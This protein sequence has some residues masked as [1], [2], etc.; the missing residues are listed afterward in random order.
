V[1]AARAANRLSTSAAAG[2]DRRRGRTERTH[3]DTGPDPPP[4]P[5]R[6]SHLPEEASESVRAPPTPEDRS[7]DAH[8]PSGVSGL[9]H[10]SHSPALLR[11][12]RRQAPQAPR[13]GAARRRPA[14]SAP[15][16]KGS[17]RCHP[18]ASGAEASAMKNAINRALSPR[19]YMINPRPLPAGVRTRDARATRSLGEAAGR[20]W[21]R[22]GS[23]YLHSRRTC[24]TG[25]PQPPLRARARASLPPRR[26]CPKTRSRCLLDRAQ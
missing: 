8:A 7:C 15:L 6:S 19:G 3:R 2:C 4:V 11:G 21:V 18:V 26:R 17:C 10:R 1:P 5:V 20:P 9:R 24:R 12:A 13:A 16:P 22:L 25:P 14:R 23:P